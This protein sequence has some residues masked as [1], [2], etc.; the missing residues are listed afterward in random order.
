MRSF[1]CGLYIL[2]CIL[3]TYL[4]AFNFWPLYCGL[5]AVSPCYGLFVVASVLAQH[6]NTASSFVRIR[7][8]ATTKERDTPRP[9]H[10]KH[11]I[12]SITALRNPGQARIRHLHAKRGASQ[13]R[14][15]VS[16]ARNTGARGLV[17]VGVRGEGR[18]KSGE[19]LGVRRGEAQ[20]SSR[21]LVGCGIGSVWLREMGLRLRVPREDDIKS[22]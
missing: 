4:T 13:T 14:Q 6:G 7:P 10:F 8:A 1:Y 16:G 2:Y 17:F 11:N 15:R 9:R 5:Y 19:G 20:Q 12:S 22:R 18:G 3:F 21:K